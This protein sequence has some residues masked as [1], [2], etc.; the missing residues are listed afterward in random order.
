[1]AVSYM[2]R[3]QQAVLDCIADRGGGC[4]T[5]AELAEELHR[6][7]Q[8]VGLTTVYRQLE[9]LEK[10]GLVHKIVTDEGACY[11]FCDCCE[12]G[13]DCFLV[14][15][16]RCGRVQHVSCDHLGALYT[17][18]FEEHQ[19]RINPRRTLFYGICDQC[20]KAEEETE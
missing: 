11:Q 3:Q 12:K 17:H 13:L 18:L 16:E 4:V 20:A 1:M 10:R 8:S 2:T 5:A 14:K 7:G 19:F 6:R 9:K 15:C